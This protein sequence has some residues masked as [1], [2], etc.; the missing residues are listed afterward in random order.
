MSIEAEPIIV[1]RDCGGDLRDDFE[2]GYRFEG[3]DAA[4]FG[5]VVPR[6]YCKRCGQEIMGDVDLQ[7][8]GAAAYL[9]E[10]RR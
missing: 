6:T 2:N 1:H 9:E 8:A 5:E 4:L 10:D 7:W 3:E